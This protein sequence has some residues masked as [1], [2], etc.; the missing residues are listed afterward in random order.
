M[1]IPG[2]LMKPSGRP[3]KPEEKRRSNVLGIRLTDS[4]MDS[5]CKVAYRTGLTISD[6]VRMVILRE[7]SVNSN[8]H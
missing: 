5:V 8:A 4:E 7:I 2:A 1:A 6:L 3:R